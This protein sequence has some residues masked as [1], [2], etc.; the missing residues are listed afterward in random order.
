MVTTR[1]ILQVGQFQVDLGVV[2]VV[3]HFY[4]CTDLRDLPLGMWPHSMKPGC[5][6][7]VCNVVSN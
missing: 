4:F 7:E 6:L 1:S 2:F 5:N 3:T